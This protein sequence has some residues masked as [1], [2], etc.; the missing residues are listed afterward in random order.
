VDPVL[1]LLSRVRPALAAACLLVASAMGVGC[2]GTAGSAASNDAPK[3]E[4]ADPPK[5]ELTPEK[6]VTEPTFVD[7]PAIAPAAELAT[8]LSTKKGSLLRLPLVIEVEPFGVGPAW[9]GTSDADRPADAVQV[10]LDQGALSVGLTERLLPLCPEAPTRCVVW[11]QGYWGPTV[12]LPGPPGF[13]GPSVPGVAKKEPFS[14]RSVVALFKDG[15]TPN[16]KVVGS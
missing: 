16:V 7:G 12:S 13:D 1:V 14:V 9:I 10:S 15:D 4:P 8:W 6:T 11:I 5:T 3:T 2:V